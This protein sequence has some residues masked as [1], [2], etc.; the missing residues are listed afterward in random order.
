M[1]IAQLRVMNANGQTISYMDLK[2][3]HS[4]PDNLK[5]DSKAAAMVNTSHF[6]KLIKQSTQVGLKTASR[7]LPV[8]TYGATM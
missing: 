8:L 7:N 5:V 1:N 2:G 4:R 3:S 6:K